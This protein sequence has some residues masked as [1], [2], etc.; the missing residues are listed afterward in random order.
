MSM[1]ALKK[2]TQ[3]V[4]NRKRFELINVHC[5]SARVLMA[6]ALLVFMC[7]LFVTPTIGK[8]IVAAI[9]VAIVSRAHRVVRI[10]VR[11]LPITR[12]IFSIGSLYFNCRHV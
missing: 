12:P 1:E 3:L 5:I 11:V 7:Y 4:I 2:H 10:P 8:H 6:F 9:I